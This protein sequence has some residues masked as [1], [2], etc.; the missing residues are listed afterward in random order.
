MINKHEII[1]NLFEGK[2]IRSV[3]NTEKEDYYFSVC[4]VISALTDNEYTKA[5]NYW[6]WLKSRLVDEGSELVSKTN[7][8]KMKAKNANDRY[9]RYQRHAKINRIYSITKSRTI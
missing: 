2:E 3:W 8:L 4:D 5:R 6:K 1:S 7:Q 9:F